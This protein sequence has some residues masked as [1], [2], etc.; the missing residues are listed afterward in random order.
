VSSPPETVV[1][2]RPSGSKLDLIQAAALAISRFGLSALT[3][4]RIATAAGHTAASIN[5]HFGSKDAL[6]L[7]TL[8]EVSD[9]FADGMAQVL[10]RSGDDALEGLL[11]II[12]ASLSAPLSESHKVAVWYAFLGESNARADYQHICGARD[13][14]YS[15]MMAALC[16]SVITA[17]GASKWPDAQAVSVGL[18]GLIDQLWQSILF[19]GDAFDREAGKRQCR[20]YLCS[21]FPWLAERIEA[22]DVPRADVPSPALALAS[23]EDV[24]ATE[25]GL[26]YTL[27]A[28]VYQNEEF[29]EL[30]KE[31]VFLPSWQIVCHVSEVGRAGDYVAFEFFGQRGFV[32][33]D[34]AGTLRAFHNVCAHRAHAVVAGERGSCEKFLRCN[35]HGW[36]YHLDGRN[37]S[38]SAPDSFPK[39]DRSRFGLK[40]IEL[41]TFMGMVFI[42]LRGGGPSVAERMQPH[43][44]ELAHYRMEEMVPLDDLWERELDIDWKNV[45]ENYVEDYHFPLGHRGLAAL[46]EP[47]YDRQMLPAGT[48]RLSHRMRETPLKS[49]SAQ[50]Y[51]KFLP[52]I[53]HLPQDMRRRWTYLG[54]LPNVF[55]D[56]YPEWLDFFHVLPTAAGRTRIR[57]RSYGFADDRR[58]M[59]AARYLCTR[60]NSRVQAEDEVLT[61][62]V[63]RGLGSGAYTQGILSDKEVVL[64]G[65]QDW[66]RA[67]L[68]V[69]RLGQ[70]PVRG[71]VAARNEAMSAQEKQA[72]RS[73]ADTTRSRDS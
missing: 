70:A 5:F 62:S 73:R 63:Q 26:R 29:H 21:V 37:R 56:I 41:E 12:E 27:P 46:M 35:Y 50:H 64:A 34:E 69:C 18:I 15:Q 58:E 14:S 4:A 33:R 13:Q 45:V 43:Q 1:E 48:L 28:W 61:R 55:F 24:A 8:R 42:R 67:R 22:G 17:H 40:P 47:Q 23:V 66:L 30:E 59:R 6:L 54:L 7:A 36:T 68:P 44:P 72:V 38:I 39:F 32:V 2:P 60:L 19:E 49:W 53:E 11:G 31:H 51:C 71:A 25:P 16:A 3:S 52:D 57:A 9:E 10:A 65:F 20:A